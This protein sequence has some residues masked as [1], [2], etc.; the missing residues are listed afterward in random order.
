MSFSAQ[1]AVQTADGRVIEFNVDFNV[2][3]E[4][5]TR[6]EISLKAG[7][8]VE[9]K[10][11]MQDPLVLN[12]AGPVATLGQR[13]FKFDLDTDGQAETLAFVGE[14]SGFLAL[15]RNDNG[16][17]DNGTELF[18]PK[19]GN[20]FQELATYDTDGDGWIDENDEIFNKLRIWSQDG[21]GNTQLMA[22]GK[23]GVGAIYLGNV[24]TP[25]RMT[26]ADGQ[27]TGQMAKSGVYLKENGQVS[28][29]QHLDLAV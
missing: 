5:M 22:L 2:S 19:T 18:G 17:V 3:Q 13:N 12:L 15:D 25:F 10:P 21:E 28:T 23:A 24:T 29:V 11:K 4:F 6:T 14:G 8:A 16:K 7:D 9:T 27:T 20:G 1:G 26:G